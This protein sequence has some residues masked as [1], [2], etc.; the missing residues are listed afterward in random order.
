MELNQKQVSLWQKFEIA[1]NTVNH[2][3]IGITTF[4]TVWY[5]LKYNFTDKLT[6]HA[7]LTTFG[8]QVLMAEAIMSY[9]KSNT[10]TLFTPKMKKS[11]IHWIMQSIGALM[12]IIGTIIEIIN[13]YE[14]KR[15]HFSTLHSVYGKLHID[16]ENP[17]NKLIIISNRFN[18]RD[19]FVLLIDFRMFR[20]ILI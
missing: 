16:N 18:F 5:C 19:I 9:Y 4:Y 2:C 12:A 15:T 1:I 11:R 17:I 6:L 7:Y 8:Y 14:M 3:L 20:F 10:Y 13:R